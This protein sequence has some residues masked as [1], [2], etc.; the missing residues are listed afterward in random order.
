MITRN[1]KRTAEFLRLLRSMEK[2]W[3]NVRSSRTLIHHRGMIYFNSIEDLNMLISFNK[4]RSQRLLE[5]NYNR[6]KCWDHGY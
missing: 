3:D 6:E 4:N 2:S 1:I 5:D